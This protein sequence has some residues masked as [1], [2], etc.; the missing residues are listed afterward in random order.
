MNE[1]LQDYIAKQDIYELSCRYMRGLDR[2]D[3]QLM[4]EQ[5]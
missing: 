1:K 3:K 5:F 2:H 4:R